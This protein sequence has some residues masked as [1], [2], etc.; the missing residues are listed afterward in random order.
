MKQYD[1]MLP[2]QYLIILVGCVYEAVGYMY[3]TV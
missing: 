2:Y 1:S 3:E